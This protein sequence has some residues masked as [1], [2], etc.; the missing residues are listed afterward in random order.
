MAALLVVGVK[1]Q[2]WVGI[3]FLN[4]DTVVDETFSAIAL[5]D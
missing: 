1:T 5:K 2:S 4:I 3:G